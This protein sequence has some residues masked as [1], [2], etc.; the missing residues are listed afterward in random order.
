MENIIGLLAVVIVAMLVFVGI[1]IKGN[2]DLLDLM[3]EINKAAKLNNDLII[4]FLDFQK[5]LMKVMM[6]A[7]Q[8]PDVRK[9]VEKLIKESETGSPGT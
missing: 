9:E 3:M 2:K 1:V 4:T 8:V 7:A 6:D 5:K